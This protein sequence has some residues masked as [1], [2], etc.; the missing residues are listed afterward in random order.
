MNTKKDKQKVINT[1][2]TIDPN[3][4][5]I[6]I[7]LHKGAGDFIAKL[8]KFEQRGPYTHSEI[9][10]MSEGKSYSSSG[11]DKGVRSKD[12]REM[13]F[14]DDSKWDLY[15][16]TIDDTYDITPFL[17]FFTKHEDSKYAMSDIIFYHILRMSIK[18]D[19][20][21]FICSD[22]CNIELEKILATISNDKRIEKLWYNKEFEY[23]RR[24]SY[25]YSPCN[26]ALKFIRY[27]LMEYRNNN[28]IFLW[29]KKED[30]QVETKSIF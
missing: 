13:N 10:V 7:A 3:D 22:F 18:I 30:T 24:N 2:I 9:I 27:N 25:K 21:R 1:N 17:D 5:R 4:K 20:N 28:D 8:M 6:F 15:Q 14:H 11:R 16:I 12:I 29:P 23:S 19:R 26:M